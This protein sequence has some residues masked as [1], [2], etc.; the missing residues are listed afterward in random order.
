[1]NSWAGLPLAKLIDQAFVAGLKFSKFFGVFFF[2]CLFQKTAYPNFKE[3]F[4]KVL[5]S[6]QCFFLRSNVHCMFPFVAAHPSGFLYCYAVLLAGA[7]AGH[8]SNWLH[9][10]GGRGQRHKRATLPS[11]ALSCWAAST[12]SNGLTSLV[13]FAS[14]TPLA[15]ILA[16]IHTCLTVLTLHISTHLVKS[17]RQ[18]CNTLGQYT[19][20]KISHLQLIA[21]WIFTILH[22]SL[23]RSYLPCLSFNSSILVVF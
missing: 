23:A 2:F 17:V 8:Q 20:Y 3:T 21:H 15:H 5:F 16:F 9:L 6:Q 1:M 7:W 18:V 12:Y 11:C 22:G 19:V 4:Q 10:T 14:V 13:W